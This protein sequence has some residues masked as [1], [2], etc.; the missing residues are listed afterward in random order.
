[1]IA[2]NEWVAS[3]FN[4]ID[5]ILDSSHSWNLQP[6]DE[7]GTVTFDTAPVRLAA[8]DF[9]AA[10]TDLDNAFDHEG[11]GSV[12]DPASVHPSHCCMYCNSCDY[13]SWSTAGP[14]PRPT[15][16]VDAAS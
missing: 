5:S 2:D 10:D 8:S 13:D 11:F 1:M 12:A 3:M 7:E 15:W 4:L 14:P 6:F 16:Y 9:H